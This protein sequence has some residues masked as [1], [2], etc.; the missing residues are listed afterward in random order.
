MAGIMRE[1]TVL[2][3]IWPGYAYQFFVDDGLKGF[4][5]L[6][7]VVLVIT[8]G[9]ALY[10]DMG[11]F[12]RRPIRLA[13]FAVAMPALVLNYFGQGALLLTDPSGIDNPFYRLVPQGLLYP[14][15]V[16]STMAA[17]VASQALISGAF[18]LTRQALQLGYSPRVTI[19]HTSRLEAGQIYIPEVN[20]LL[21]IAC[22]ALVIGFQTSTNLAGAYGIAVT[23]T[24]SITTILFSQVALHRWGWPVWRVALVTGTFLVVDLAFFSANI[25]KI[26]AGGW[27]PIVLAVTIFVLMTTWKR[28]RSIVTAVLREGTLPM[29]LFIKELSKRPPVRVPGV[30]VFMTSD[31]SGAPPVLLHHLKHNKV[32]HEKVILMCMATQEIPQVAPEERIEFCDLGWGVHT[33]VA[34]Y[35][36]MESPNVPDILQRLEARG[37]TARVNETSFYL[38]R[39]TVIP[40]T[41]SPASR[42]ALAAKGLWMAVWRKRIFMVMTNNALSATAFFGIPPNRVVE[43]GAQVQI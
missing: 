28:G 26:P 2:R 20:R 35:G 14:M 5:I 39:E 11:H 12:G 3:A 16:I 29:D 9:E 6:G 41:A 13:W 23:G 18:S 21:M 31:L 24:M 38:G 17:V 42:A 25:V 27:F 34:S 30:A 32:L 7:S 1:P 33:V 36:F 37:I 40:T 43:L 4:L 19:V 10:A 8:G 15:V 22:L